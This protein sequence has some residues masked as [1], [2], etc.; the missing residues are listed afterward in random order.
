MAGERER[1]RRDGPSLPDGSRPT[2]D[3][4]ITTPVDGWTR[5]GR[6]LAAS[7]EAVGDGGKLRTPLAAGKLPVRDSRFGSVDVPRFFQPGVTEVSSI[8][9]APGF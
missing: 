1:S 4:W 9:G 7:D 3:L 8:C 2:A 5:L 6:A